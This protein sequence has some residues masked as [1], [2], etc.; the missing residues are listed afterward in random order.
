[1]EDT[2]DGETRNCARRSEI[3]NRDIVV[4][5]YLEFCSVLA[6]SAYPD[7]HCYP[8]MIRDPPSESGV[9]VMEIRSFRS[10]ARIRFNQPTG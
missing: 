8:Q 2:I 4:Y 9:F 3:F 6:L 7:D 10:S 1:M 5:C